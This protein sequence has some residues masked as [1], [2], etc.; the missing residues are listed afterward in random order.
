MKLK[1]DYPTDADNP[2]MVD[3][4]INKLLCGNKDD[5]NTFLGYILHRDMKLEKAFTGD[6]KSSILDLYI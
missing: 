2:N 3:E 5:I 6:G 1:F 4:I